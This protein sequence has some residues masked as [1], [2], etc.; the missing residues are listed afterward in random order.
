MSIVTILVV[1]GIALV[2]LVLQSIRLRL[3]ITL[4]S[5]PP[6]IHTGRIKGE[7][8]HITARESERPYPK[9]HDQPPTDQGG[10]Y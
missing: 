5:P 2:G 9:D 8:S 4:G 7:A 10:W 6:I 3:G 1:S